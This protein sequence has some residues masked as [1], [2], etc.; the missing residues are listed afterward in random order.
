MTEDYGVWKQKIRRAL[1]DYDMFGAGVAAERNNV[2]V[3]T[4]YRWRQV[5]TEHGLGAIPLRGHR[6]IGVSSRTRR[7]AL[8][9]YPK[10]GE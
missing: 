9:T 10:K 2:T 8:E 3:T 7:A 4:I 6:P 5:A 1:H